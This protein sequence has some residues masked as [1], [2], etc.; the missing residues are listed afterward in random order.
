MENFTFFNTNDIS[1]HIQHRDGEIKFGESLVTVS[2]LDQ[3]TECDTDYVLFGIPEDLGIIANFGNSGASKTFQHVLSS[4]LN[5][6]NNIF[7]NP[8]NLLVL[9]QVNCDAFYK[10]AKKMNPESENYRTQLGEIV[11]K[12]DDVVTAVVKAIIE[13]GK[14]PVVVGGGHNNSYGIIRGASIALEN[15]INVLNIDAH[16]DLRPTNYRHSGNGVRYALE[17]NYL[18]KYHVFGLHKN[19]NSQEI[20]DFMDDTKVLNYFLYED[21]LHLTTLDKCIRVKNGVDFLNR[22]FGFELD[23]D[24][25]GGMNSSA[26]TPSGFS[27]RD[28]R[29]FI[30][31]IKK[32]HVHY[33]HICEADASKDETIGKTISYFIS[34]FIRAED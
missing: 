13:S 24:A 32:E 9:G 8:K 27:I 22:T 31:L 18:N 3:L 19:Y 34:D 16:S 29:T 28:I 33:F 7:N 4:L 2:E 14:T 21:A 5:I 12:I 15:P 17:E 10:E 30:K 1:R 23:C 25:I 6:Q 26:Q 20:F 11:S